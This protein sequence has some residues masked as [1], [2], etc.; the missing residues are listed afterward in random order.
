M[1]TDEEQNL[2]SKLD[3]KISLKTCCCRSR[4]T[5]VLGSNETALVFRRRRH[6]DGLVRGRTCRRRRLR[7]RRGPSGLAQNHVR[8]L[9]GD[10]SRRVRRARDSLRPRAGVNVW[11]PRQ[12]GFSDFRRRVLLFGQRDASSRLPR[13]VGTDPVFRGFVRA[14][15]SWSL[16]GSPLRRD[17]RLLQLWRS[18]LLRLLGPSPPI[19][20]A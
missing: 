9:D 17:D 11:D 3:P 4:S 18:V 16:A 10:H 2:S 15:I 20:G 6:F 13:S 5:D 7:R 12:I 1:G 19:S 14:S 8:G